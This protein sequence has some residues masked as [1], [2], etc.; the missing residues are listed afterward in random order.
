MDVRI[1]PEQQKVQETCKRLA[2]DFATR[3]AQHDRERS[4]PV[5]N[6]AAIKREGLYALPV[7]KDLGGLGTGYFG[8]V[9]AA[10]QLAQG[11]PTTAITF[12]MHCTFT[13]LF[14]DQPAVARETKQ[15]LANLV[16]REQ[17]LLCASVSEAGTSSLLV[18]PTFTPNTQARRVNGGYVLRGRKSFVSMVEG[19]D[20]IGLLAHP[21][22]NPSPL[23]CRWFVVP[24]PSPGLRVEDVW[25]TLGMRGTRSNDL[26]LE[27]CYVPDENF[28]HEDETGLTLEGRK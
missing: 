18:A 5:E 21:E 20:Y 13:G 25:D 26:I 17:K 19:C 12:N 1:T 24:Y 10:E 4:L 11:C 22:G 8:Y 23:A 16:V 3:S 15:R 9:L 14:F 7:P 6:Y 2:A 27:D 28:L